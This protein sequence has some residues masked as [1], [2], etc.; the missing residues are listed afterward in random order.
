MSTGADI[1]ELLPLYAL[2]VLDDDEATRVEAAIARDPSLAVEL[3]AYEDAATSVLTPVTPDPE[4]KVRLMASIGESRF[5]KFSARL[6]ALFDVTVERA[7]EILGLMER[8]AS[9]E[10]AMPGLGLVHFDGGPAYATADCGFIR[11]APGTSF[12][13][14]THMGEEVSLILAGEIQDKQTGVIYRAGDEVVKPVDSEHDVVSVGNEDA[15]YAAR[16]MNGIAIAGAP[17]RPS[18]R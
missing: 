7:R 6:A 1:K 11:L 4:V 18:R 10:H 13:H 17:A 5:E 14:H 3:S 16:A 2:G 9:W 15:I 12:P 8:K